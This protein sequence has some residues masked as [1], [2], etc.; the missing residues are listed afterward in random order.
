MREIN[1]GLGSPACPAPKR[2]ILRFFYESVK[3]G[4]LGYA[5]TNGMRE[6]R[7]A[8][9]WWQNARHG[10][11]GLDPDANVT[12]AEGSRLLLVSAFEALFQPGDSVILP[13]R[14][15]NG[16]MDAV[17][18][19]RLQPV[20]VSMPS[21]SAYVDGI[22]ELVRA[23]TR[24]KAVVTCF[25]SNPTGLSC[26][27][28][29]Y[30]RLVA[31]AHQYQF[32]VLD[33]YAYGALD[34]RQGYVPSSLS[35]PGA[36]DVVLWFGTASKMFSAASWKVGFCAGSKDH[37]ALITRTKSLYSEGGSRPGQLATAT[38][39]R[40][41]GA[42]VDR[43]RETYRHRAELTT[44]LLREAGLVDAKAPDG[45]M[46][47]WY[48]VPQGYQGG[49]VR[50]ATELATRGVVVRDDR[51]YGGSGTHIRWCLRVS[52]AETRTAC[53]HVADVLKK[54]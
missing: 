54:G 37:I 3:R 2:A 13:S 6:A 40:F 21:A 42:D 9:C 11:R 51:L 44:R 23:G 50:L 20:L 29:E 34:Y 4:G 1:L 53:E 48:P 17:K 39:L 15:Y 16:H 47:G 31:L 45:G 26:T 25:V 28:S 5:P 52:D 30:Q 46:F 41:C 32:L 43:T 33:D 8:V 35:V 18:K 38:A 24:P 22:E 36:L 14:F 27:A 12:F 19:F 49:S 10:V 7:E